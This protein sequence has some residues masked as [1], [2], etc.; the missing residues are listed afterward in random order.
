MQHQQ[1]VNSAE[2]N[3]RRAS[4]GHSAVI[5][6]GASIASLNQLLAD[7]LTLRD[8]YKKHQ[9]QVTGRNFYSLQLLFEKSGQEQ[10]RLADLLAER[11]VALGGDPVAMPHDIARMTRLA[12]PPKGPETAADEISRLLDAHELILGL[13]SDAADMAE[14]RG[15]H[16]SCDLLGGEAVRIN[17]VQIWSLLQHLSDLPPVEQRV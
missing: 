8:L 14:G 1:R 4:G 12:R 5:G 13:S 10:M 6:H 15:D 16:Y 3:A 17:E 2:A 9:W 7:T 11:I